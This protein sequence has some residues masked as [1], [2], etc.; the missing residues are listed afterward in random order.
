MTRK[1]DVFRIRLAG[2]PMELRC[3]YPFSRAFCADYLTTDE[4]QA[5]IEVSEQDV[6][7]ER[8]KS[9]REAVY[10]GLPPIDYPDD[11]LE[12]VA[13]Y[14]KIALE[15]TKHD[16]AVFHGAVVAVDGEAYAFTASSGTGKTTHMNLWLRHFG[17][18]ALVV[19]GDK[20]ILRVDGERVFA[21]GTPWC[22]KENLNTNVVL[23]LKAICILER[24]AV[25]HI[26]RIGMGDALAVLMQQIY[27]PAESDALRR[28]VQ[29]V[30]KLGSLVK[31]Y[32]LGC[33]MEEEA[34][35][36]AYEGMNP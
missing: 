11:Y 29:L 16:A 19:N 17:D 25:N 5:V 8:E 3:R 27:R 12:S 18:R 4:P 24:D 31:L 13:A 32:R 14:R 23:P 9:L 35:V 34:A 26:E 21:C 10:E 20:P 22:G 7:F 15:M 30:G 2:L 33:N 6:A 1:M 28:T 36:I